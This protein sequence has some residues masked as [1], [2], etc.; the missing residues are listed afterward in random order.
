MAQLYITC[1]NT[2]IAAIIKNIKHRE[3]VHGAFASLFYASKG[4][5][6]G[7]ISYIKIPNPICNHAAMYEKTISA[8]GF[9]HPWRDVDDSD[10]IM[11]HLLT[12]NKLHLHQAWETPFTTGPLKEYIGNYGLGQGATKILEED[13]DPNKNKNIP[14]VNY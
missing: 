1:N 6:A 14:A 4:G 13:F 7:C 11:D 5:Q 12:C 2:N 3:E 8:L 10:N 9:Q